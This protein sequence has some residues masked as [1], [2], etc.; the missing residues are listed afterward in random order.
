MPPSPTGAA[1]VLGLE[2]GELMAMLEIAM[3]G[4]VPY[5][6][7]REA[8][9]V[10]EPTDILPAFDQAKKWMKQYRVPVVVEIILER[11][12]NVSMGTEL[13]GGGLVTPSSLKVAEDNYVRQ[14]SLFEQK[15]LSQAEWDRAA[16]RSSGRA[17]PVSRSARSAFPPPRAHSP[18][19]LYCAPSS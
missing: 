4:K 3:L 1:A 14:K 10:L 2:G 11:V 8:I 5:P 15:L 18:A 9:R 6:V 19:A 17:A 13:G 7:L 12:T 16:R